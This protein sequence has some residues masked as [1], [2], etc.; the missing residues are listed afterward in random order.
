MGQEQDVGAVAAA[1]VRHVLPTPAS[2]RLE[3]TSGECGIGL[4]LTYPPVRCWPEPRPESAA[5]ELILIDSI[6]QR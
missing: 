1:M 3:V 6:T 4:H 5:G 2:L